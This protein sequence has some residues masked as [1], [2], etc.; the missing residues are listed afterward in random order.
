MKNQNS[1]NK[2]VITEGFIID[3]NKLS[4]YLNN[5]FKLLLINFEAIIY[6]VNCLSLHHFS[7]YYYDYFLIN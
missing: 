6:F 4:K 7:A 1:E 3:Q 2:L 5:H